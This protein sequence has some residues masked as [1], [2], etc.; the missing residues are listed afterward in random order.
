MYLFGFDKRYVHKF[1]VRFNNL[2][3]EVTKKQLKVASWGLKR[4]N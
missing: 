4:T 3:L 1:Q 2:T